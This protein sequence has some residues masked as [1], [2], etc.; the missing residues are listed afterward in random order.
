MRDLL[1]AEH[2]TRLEALMLR[3]P[4]HAEARDCRSTKR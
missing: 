4:L 2:E 1:F 3:D